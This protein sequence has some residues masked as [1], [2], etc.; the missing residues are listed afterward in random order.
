[1]RIALLGCAHVHADSYAHCLGEVSGVTFPGIFDPDHRS[2]ERAAARHGVQFFSS[3]DEAIASAEAVL[4]ASATSDHRRLAVAA[5]RAGRHVLCEKPLATTLA[6]ADAMVAAAREARVVL[7]TAF[8]MRFAPPVTSAWRA[9]RAGAVGRILA[10]SGAN[11]GQLPSPR[12]FS[13]P[14]LAGGGAV[15]DHTVHL[16]DLM[17]WFTREEIVEVYAEVDTLLHDVRVDDVG[18]LALRMSGGAV[19]TID[20]SWNRPAGYPTWGGLELRIVAEDGVID[21]DAFAQRLP[22]YGRHSTAWVGW[23]SDADRAMLEAFVSAC[24]G[25]ATPLA[26]GEDGLAA[27]GIVLAAYESARTGAPVHMPGNRTI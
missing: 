21:I 25:H 23:G 12:W 2:G 24:A 27:L 15:M 7:G 11:N 4:I 14:E 3:A 22:V 1:M 18:V 17:R 10:F 19:G 5:S 20:A 13:D 9:L 6:D 8:P 26:T 16:A